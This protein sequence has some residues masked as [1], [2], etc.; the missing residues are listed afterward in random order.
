MAANVPVYPACVVRESLLVKVIDEAGQPL[1]DA[2]VIVTC[3]EA[4]QEVTRGATLTD[5]SGLTPADPE[6]SA[7]VVTLKRFQATDDPRMPKTT[8]FSYE[9]A[10]RKKEFKPK[11]VTLS[12][13]QPVA[14]PLTIKLEREE[15]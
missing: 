9:V 11:T 15:R 5:H 13:G 3:K 14:R 8:T 2:V 1:P 12:A 4:P 7:I 10:I 6:A